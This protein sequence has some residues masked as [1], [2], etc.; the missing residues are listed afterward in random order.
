MLYNWLSAENWQLA[1]RVKVRYIKQRMV[2]CSYHSLVHSCPSKAEEPSS[3][4]GDLWDARWDPKDEGRVPEADAADTSRTRCCCCEWYNIFI[5]FFL[6]QFVPFVS[7]ASLTIL[8]NIIFPVLFLH[9]FVF[10]SHT[11]VKS[12]NPHHLFQS[13]IFQQ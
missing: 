3:S 12:S 2:A 7:V 6:H 13:P 11:P 9:T 1:S 8:I 10:L 5:F 4:A